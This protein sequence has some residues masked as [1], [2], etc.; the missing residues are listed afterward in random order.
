MTILFVS[1]VNDHS[2]IRVTLDRQNQPT[3]LSDGNC[4]INGRI[5]FKRGV[6]SYVTL[7]GEGVRQQGF[8]F[9][10]PPSLIVNQ[11]ANPDTHGGSLR[12]CIE[13][14]S[15]VNSPVI[16][17]PE[18]ILQTTRDG[19]SQALQGIPGVIMPRTVRFQPMCPED[20]LVRAEAENFDW[21]FIVRQAGLHGG[22]SM[23][24]VN[25]REDYSSL[26]VFPF[27]GRDFYLTQFVDCRNAEGFYPRQRLIV[28]D[29]TPVLRGALYNDNWKVHGASRSFMLKRE[30]WEADRER[31][32]WFENQVIPK[33]NAAI[34]EITRRLKLEL[35]GMDCSLGADGSMIIFEANANMNIFANEH[36]QMNTRMDLVKE[37]ILA[38]LARHSGEQ[39]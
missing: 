33:L 3:Y 36:P 38:M 8:T 22:Q 28:I 21:P 5:P 25:G 20:V 34:A 14:C 24:C 13:F 30:T 11:I 29:G 16:N 1:G 23:I 31:N 7:Y 37:R 39:I 27:D 32:H 9:L 18:H 35:Y 26:H 12:R 4:Y 10:K 19:V 17:R 2:L 6:A 15:Q